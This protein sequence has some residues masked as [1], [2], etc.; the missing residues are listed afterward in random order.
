MD[1][2]RVE[3]VLVRPRRAA[4]VAAA[5]RAMKNMGLRTLW[6]VEPG[7]GLDDPEPRSLAYGAW[8]VLDGARQATSLLEAVSGSRAVVGTTGRQVPGARTPREVAARAATLAG[9]GALSLVFGPEASGLSGAELDLCHS[10]VHVPTDPGHPSL[11]LA[12]AVLLVAYEMRLAARAEHGPA[13]AE[14]GDPRAPAGALEQALRELR[15]ALLEI[16]YLD[17][18]SPDRVLTELRRLVARARPTTREV[19]LLR[20]LARQMAWA[21]RIARGGSGPHNPPR[22]AR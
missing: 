4:N 3:I 10:L 13:T 8:D 17:P 11:N 15:G 6:L 9:E 22:G 1:L 12:Q 7:P 14:A 16:G 2:D 19:V 18:A 5:C 20:G 21:G